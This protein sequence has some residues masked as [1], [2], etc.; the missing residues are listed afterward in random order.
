MPKI[1][2]RPLS[3]TTGLLLYALLDL[4]LVGVAVNAAFGPMLEGSDRTLSNTIAVTMLIAAV[5]VGW[6][7]VRAFR[8]KR[9]ARKSLMYLTAVLLIILYWRRLGIFILLAA[10]G[11]LA[12]VFLWLPASNAFFQRTEPRRQ[13]LRRYANAT[14][15]AANVWRRRSESDDVRR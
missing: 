11:T 13:R 8:G 1:T 15:R 6:E 10:L 7:T 2:D 4:A 14:T 5:A 9:S 12:A 3:L